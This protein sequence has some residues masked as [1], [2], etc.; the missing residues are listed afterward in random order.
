VLH[1][2]NCADASL[3]S[4]NPS[5]YSGNPRTFPSTSSTQKQIIQCFNNPKEKPKN[6]NNLTENDSNQ[7]LGQ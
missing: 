6:P 7:E 4:S 2:A 3:C 1:G 5:F